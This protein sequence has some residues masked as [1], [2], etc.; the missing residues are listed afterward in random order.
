M[1]VTYDGVAWDSVPAKGQEAGLGGG[2]PP[3][4][5]RCFEVVLTLPSELGELGVGLPCH[6]GQS[7]GAA[8]LANLLATGWKLQEICR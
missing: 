1:L 7:P 8:A 4:Y 2:R 6:G 5:Q 3:Q